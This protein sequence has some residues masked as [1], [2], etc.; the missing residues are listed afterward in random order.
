VSPLE[1][2]DLWFL[3][4]AYTGLFVVMFGFLYRMFLHTRHL[5]QEVEL[6]REE[7]GGEGA[8]YRSGREMGKSDLTV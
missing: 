3:F 5:E 6:L 8:S 7:Y 2:Q 1:R 4:F